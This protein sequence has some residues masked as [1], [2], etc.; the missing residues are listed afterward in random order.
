M[1]IGVKSVIFD[2]FKPST[3]IEKAMVNEA[4][5]FI[6]KKHNGVLYNAHL[7]ST[8]IIEVAKT[9]AD[10]TKVHYRKYVVFLFPFGDEYEAVE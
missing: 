4:Q 7:L 3:E 1:A 5:S 9:E 6:E 8:R 10:L 2:T